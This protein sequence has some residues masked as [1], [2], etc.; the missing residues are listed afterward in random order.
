[1]TIHGQQQAIEERI[2]RLKDTKSALV[3]SINERSKAVKDTMSEGRQVID[4]K[5]A[6]IEFLVHAN[7]IVVRMFDCLCGDIRLRMNLSNDHLSAIAYAVQNALEKQIHDKREWVDKYAAALA[8]RNEE[9]KRLS[10]LLKFLETNPFAPT[11][12]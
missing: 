1:M 12:Q 9:L 6:E 3:D 7:E 5:K 8:R 10:D 4:C 11:V 2:A